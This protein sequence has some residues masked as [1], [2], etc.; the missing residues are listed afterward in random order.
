[1][2]SAVA[3]ELNVESDLWYRATRLHTIRSCTSSMLVRGRFMDPLDLHLSSHRKSP[4]TQ[5]EE[6][7]SGGMRVIH[8]A[9][10]PNLKQMLSLCSTCLPSLPHLDV[11]A[12][13]RDLPTDSEMARTLSFRVRWFGLAE[14]HRWSARWML[15]SANFVRKVCES[16][17]SYLRIALDQLRDFAKP[18]RHGLVVE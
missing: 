10:N 4:S 6:K 2:W 12:L 1:M 18:R 9:R 15:T 16:I 5:S 14:E 8:D 13:L 11:A 7:R 3:R 17:Q